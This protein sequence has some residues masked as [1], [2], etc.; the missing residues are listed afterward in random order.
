MKKIFLAV[1]IVC[2]SAVSALAAT[3]NSPIGPGVDVES[4]E[5]NPVSIGRL[6]PNV[7]LSYNTDEDGYAIATVNKKGTKVYGGSFDSTSMYVADKADVGNS[8]NS[9]TLGAA[10]SSSFDG[11]D[12]ESI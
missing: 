6:S 5:D 4:A 11:D 7:Y 3:T 12:W 9:V 8:D 1:S 10:D 2:L